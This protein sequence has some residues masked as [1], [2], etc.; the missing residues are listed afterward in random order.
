ML[1]SVFS[2]GI[3]EQNPVRRGIDVV[4]LPIPGRPDKGGGGDRGQ[5]QRHRGHDKDN[6]QSYPSSGLEALKP[7]A[8]AEVSTAA[9]LIGMSTAASNGV[10]QPATANETAMAL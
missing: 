9:E 8:Q 3:V 1:G 7:N 5:Q 6:G 10:I 4:E 2:L